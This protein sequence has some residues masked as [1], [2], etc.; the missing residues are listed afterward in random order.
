MLN[1]VIIILAAVAAAL[2]VAAGGYVRDEGDEIQVTQRAAGEES[3]PVR[4]YVERL[5]VAPSASIVE[6]DPPVQPKARTPIAPPKRPNPS[7]VPARKRG[8]S[9]PRIVIDKSDKRLTLYD[10]YRVVKTYPVI[11][12]SRSGDK[13]KKGDRRTPEGTFYVCVR[14]P[15]SRYAEFGAELP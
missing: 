12:G 15:V 2:L 3:S 1:R 7:P 13:V 5:P 8:L 9:R 11:T 6:Q 14:N 4:V 10:G